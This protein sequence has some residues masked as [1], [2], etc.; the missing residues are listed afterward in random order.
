MIYS[1]DGF[2][3][4]ELLKKKFNSGRRIVHNF[5]AAVHTEEKLCQYHSRIA[6]A[7]VHT[8]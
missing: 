7:A 3:I 4:V 5:N 8:Q 1:C 2:L 6:S